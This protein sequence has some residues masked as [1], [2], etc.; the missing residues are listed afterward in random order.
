MTKITKSS[1]DPVAQSP[2]LCGVF[3]FPERSS[4]SI[5]RY[6][7]QVGESLYTNLACCHTKRLCHV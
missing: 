7:G 3:L 1:S 2:M 4:A 6:T 5:D